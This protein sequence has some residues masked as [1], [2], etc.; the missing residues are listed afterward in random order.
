MKG[1]RKN[2]LVDMAAGSMEMVSTGI[3]V[4]NELGIRVNKV[5]YGSKVKNHPVDIDFVAVT[6]K[7]AAILMEAGAAAKEELIKRK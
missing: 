7:G 1:K 4:L 6:E 5:S 3:M 2:N